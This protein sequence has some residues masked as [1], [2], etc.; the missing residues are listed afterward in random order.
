MGYGKGANMT[1]G[2]S[3]RDFHVG[4]HLGRA[5]EG[6]QVEGRE[7]VEKVEGWER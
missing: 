3:Q 1:K 7:R 5:A 6:L 4:W 2:D